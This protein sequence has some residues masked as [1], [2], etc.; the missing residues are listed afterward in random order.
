MAAPRRKKKPNVQAKQVGS[1]FGLPDVGNPFGALAT[2]PG[3]GTTKNIPSLTEQVAL[4]RARRQRLQQGGLLTPAQRTAEQ[5]AAAVVPSKAAFAVPPQEGKRSAP[6]APARSSEKKQEPAKRV[7]GRTGVPFSP[8][9]Q[10]GGPGLGD[11][12]DRLNEPLIGK[13]AAAAV[14]KNVLAPAYRVGNLAFGTGA[15]AVLAGLGVGDPSIL[16]KSALKRSSYVGPEDA[17]ARISKAGLTRPDISIPRTD[18]S[19]TGTAYGAGPQSARIPFKDLAGQTGWSLTPEAKKRAIK[20][21]HD[22][23]GWNMSDLDGLSASDL[24]YRMYNKPPS[25]LARIGKGIASDVVMGGSQTVGAVGLLSEASQGR[26]VQAG[27]DLLS[28]LK[29][30]TPGLSNHPALDTLVTHPLFAATALHGGLKTVGSLGHLMPRIPGERIVPLKGIEGSPT[31]N[32]GSRSRNLVTAATDE[33]GDLRLRHS[34]RASGKAARDEI[35]EH[36]RT[37]RN[38]NAHEHLAVQVPYRTAANA[39]K[40]DRKKE[41]MAWADFGGEPALRNGIVHFEGE[42]RN[43]NKAGARLLPTLHAALERPPTTPAE[44]AYVDSLRDISKHTSDERQHEGLHGEIAQNYR[45]YETPIEMAASAG[46]PLAITA[47]TARDNLDELQNRGPQEA[48]PGARAKVTEVERD[49]KRHTKKAVPTREEWQAAGRELQ[50]RRPKPPKVASERAKTKYADDMRQWRNE[51][52]RHTRQGGRITAHETEVRQQGKRLDRLTAAQ[53][54]ALPYDEQL[55]LARNDAAHSTQAFI[56]AHLAAGGVEASRI[57]RTKIK[58]G[59]AHPS[60]LAGK[61]RFTTKTQR[62][63]RSSGHSIRSGEFVYDPRAPLHENAE[64]QRI[65]QHIGIWNDLAQNRMVH[66]VVGDGETTVVGEGQVAVPIDNF[67]SAAKT[68]PPWDDSTPVAMHEVDR[69]HTIRQKAAD[70]MKGTA[71]TEGEV[72][73]RGQEVFVLPAAMHN[74]IIE[75]AKPVSRDGKM[76]AYERA[77]AA[78]QRILIGIYPSTWLGNAPGS[79]P[80]AIASGAIPGRGAFKMAA[81]SGQ[82]K[83]PLARALSSDAAIS[84][85]S[86]SGLGAAGS[87]MGPAGNPLMKFVGFGRELS[88]KGE[89]FSARAAWFGQAKP[90]VEGWLPKTRKLF[91]GVEKLIP[92]S[93]LGLARELNKDATTIYHALASA[94]WE[95]GTRLSPEL[96]ATRNRMLNHVEEFVSASVKPKGDLGRA[97]G[98]VVLFH[99]WLG[100]ILKLTLVSLPLNHPRR[101]ALMNAISVYGNQYRQEHGVYPSWMTQFLPLMEQSQS[102]GNGLSAPGMLSAGLGQLTPM[103]SATSLAGAGTQLDTRSPL[104]L[105]ASLTSPLVRPLLQAAIALHDNSKLR[106]GEPGAIDPTKVLLA[107]IQSAIPGSA[108]FLPRSGLTPEANILTGMTKRKYYEYVPNASGKSYKRYEVPWA[109]RPGGRPQGGA[110]GD[111]F[112]VLGLPLEWNPTGGIPLKV[113]QG[114]NETINRVNEVKRELK[115]AKG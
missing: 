39:L 51:K 59:I 44:I 22:V 63:Y 40:D 84:P 29:S 60:R 1:L 11:V 45:Q 12:W 115:K 31:V 23:Q 6:V 65:R 46:D 72:I 52:A 114:N 86:I 26:G 30:V 28:S 76:A 70:W 98:T 113:E 4:A 47:K 66:H 33:L 2:T 5:G 83:G 112:R 62:G 43:G 111:A 101:A 53:R 79:V 54:D 109:M 67:R 25:L 16:T 78:Y 106:P 100:H 42:A 13:G 96:E 69:E 9:Q 35:D 37:H 94:K 27:E 92:K 38:L 32:R 107:G 41:L 87:S 20:V 110:L 108:K 21:A 7:A 61:Q 97:V 93:K 49:V 15:S 82:T 50:A 57:P 103:A 3:R 8:G 17:L 68:A 75:W 74:R 71:A 19:F 80:L 85:A 99:N 105:G 18:L 88:M 58:S 77:N 14:G 81:K 90:V 55:E 89:D 36:V 95:D 10:R 102:I 91:P 34:V 24:V 104:E 64:I 73:P 48:T 56:D